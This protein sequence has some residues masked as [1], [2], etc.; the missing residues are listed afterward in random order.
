MNYFLDFVTVIQRF[1]KFLNIFVAIFKCNVFSIF[2][3]EK[4][5]PI[6]SQFFGAFVC[7]FVF[8]NFLITFDFVHEKTPEIRRT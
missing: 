3:L 1:P 5:V 6:A 2:Q 7:L 4:V 8:L